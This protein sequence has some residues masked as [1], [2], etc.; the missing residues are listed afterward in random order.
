VKELGWEIRGHR[1]KTRL[2][3]SFKKR[4]RKEKEKS[5]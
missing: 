4:K 3:L 2:W 1:F 5:Q